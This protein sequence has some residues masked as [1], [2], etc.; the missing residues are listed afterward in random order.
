[1]STRGSSTGGSR[2]DTSSAAGICASTTARTD[3]STIGNRLPE[4]RV[5]H[6]VR[7]CGTDR[8]GSAE[9]NQQRTRRGRKEPEVELPRR[10]TSV[11]R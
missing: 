6:G 8:G 5:R 9:Q 4:L 3:A 10:W 2:R 11:T 1:M 7:R